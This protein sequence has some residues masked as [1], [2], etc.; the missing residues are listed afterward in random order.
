LHIR[1][2]G[3]RVLP[4]FTVDPKSYYEK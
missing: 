4:Y 3:Y 1:P 2:G